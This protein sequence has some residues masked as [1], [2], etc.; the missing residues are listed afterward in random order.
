M[1]QMPDRPRDRRAGCDGSHRGRRRTP[2]RRRA[3]TGTAAMATTP[4]VVPTPSTS[5]CERRRSRPPSAPDQ[6]PE[7]HHGQDHHHVV[8][9]RGEGGRREAP[10]PVEH[11]GG[12][13][14]D[15]VEQHLGHEQPQQEAAQLHLGVTDGLVGHGDRERPHDPRPGQEA[16]DHDRTQ[17]RQGQAQHGP[18]Q[19][20]GVLPAT[21]VEQGDERRHQH[22]REDAGGQELE[23]QVG[24]QV[25]RLVGVAQVGRAQRPADGHHPEEPGDAGREVAGGD[26]GPRSPEAHEVGWGST[27]W[28]SRPTP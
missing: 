24:D 1:P 20:L 5:R 23:E 14:A 13:R 8:G 25:G 12:H 9:D 21:L 22:R 18:G 4:A 16:E 17:H 27:C 19:P 6:R 2:A 11:G 10:G 7:G 28:A 26:L 15:G 3:I